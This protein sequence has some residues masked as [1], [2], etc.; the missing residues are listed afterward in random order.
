MTGLVWQQ[1]VLICYLAYAALAVVAFIGK[2][3]PAVTN[4]SA[5]TVLIVVAAEI[6]LIV[7]IR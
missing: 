2:P 5:I 7:S 4:R 6:A 3:R 1:W